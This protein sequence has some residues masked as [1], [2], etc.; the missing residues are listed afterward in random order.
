MRATC[1]SVPAAAVRNV[2]QSSLFADSIASPS[3][4]HSP[5]IAPRSAAVAPRVVG[6]VAVRGAEAVARANVQGV[7]G[8]DAA[9][10]LHLDTGVIPPGQE[11]V[12][13]END[14]LGRPRLPVVI[15]DVPLSVKDLQVQFGVVALRVDQLHDV[16]VVAAE[17]AVE[18]EDVNVRRGADHAGRA[19]DAAD[20]RQEPGGRRRAADVAVV[21]Q[22][23]E[24]QLEGQ[25]INALLKIV[26]A[27]R[28]GNQ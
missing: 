7:V 18:R 22:H 28:P 2:N 16:G 11:R 5:A 12:A 14:V 10:V 8:R 6:L 23:L 24:R 3:R 13:P 20:P 9:E 27:A 17:V 1:P 19:A 21:G 25:A 26:L 15:A 4:V